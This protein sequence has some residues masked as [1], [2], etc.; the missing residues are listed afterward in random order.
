MYVYQNSI[1][2]YNVYPNSRGMY[3]V[4]V[5]H[6]NTR[7]FIINHHIYML[8]TTPV[9]CSM[10]HTVSFKRNVIFTMAC[11]DVI[12]C[13]SYYC[14][15]HYNNYS[16]GTK[17]QIFIAKLL[18]HLLICQYYL[19]NVWYI[20]MPRMIQLFLQHQ[21]TMVREHFFRSF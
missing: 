12:Q 10:I 11:M 19:I 2:M 4:Y 9:P 1:D 8:D 5:Y 17:H 18:L 15:F 21:I 13:L 14:K 6:H 16:V 3:N 20:D 7:M